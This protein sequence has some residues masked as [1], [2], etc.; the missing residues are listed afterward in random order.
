MKFRLLVITAATVV[1]ASAA[2]ATCYP[3]PSQGVYGNCEMA[4]LP[5]FVTDAMQRA[6]QPPQTY[7]QPYQPQHTTSGVLPGLIPAQGN[8]HGD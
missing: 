4:P 3:D 1:C 8:D 7:V 6:W 2:H 5:R